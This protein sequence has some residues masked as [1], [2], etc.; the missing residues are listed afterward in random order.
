MYTKI[1]HHYC[2]LDGASN[3]SPES[4][5]ELGLMVAMDDQAMGKELVG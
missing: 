5:C 2:E 4:R 1:I 3:M